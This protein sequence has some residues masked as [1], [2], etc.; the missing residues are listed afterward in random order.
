VSHVVKVIFYDLLIHLYIQQISGRHRYT[1]I[2][3]C[4][5]W[6]QTKI[7]YYSLQGK[8]VFWTLEPRVPAQV[9]SP[10][11]WVA[12]K[13]LRCPGDAEGSMPILT[14]SSWHLLSFPNSAFCPAGV[15]LPSTLWQSCF[16]NATLVSILVITFS[17]LT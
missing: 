16:Y 13:I 1:Y 17:D 3:V 2:C 10:G 9:W 7:F 15:V 11:L 14:V 4:M 5:L 8:M 6:M 12:L